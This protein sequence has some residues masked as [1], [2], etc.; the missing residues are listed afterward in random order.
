MQEHL[1][2]KLRF[3]FRN[4]PVTSARP[5]AYRVALA[6]E[7]A[8]TEDRFWDMYDYL[9]RHGQTNTDENLRN[10][11]PAWVCKLTNSIVTL[12]SKLVKCT[13]DED[14]ESGKSSGVRNTPTFSINGDR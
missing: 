9:F 14:I 10:L 1:G 5:R 4:F 12:M 6:A 11:E 3:V 2:T 7:A 13:S 8:A